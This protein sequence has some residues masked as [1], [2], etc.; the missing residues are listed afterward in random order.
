MWGSI[1]HRASGVALYAGAAVVVA[2][3][4]CLAAGPECYTCFVA[5]MSSP[6]G[7]LLWLG[8]SAAAFYHLFSGLRHLVWDMG[9]GL[10]PKTANSMATWSILLAIAATAAY[11]AWLFLSG[12][13]HL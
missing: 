5:L 12:K 7:L 2:W 10:T 3:L 1:L 4:S 6:I 9:A 13:V 11:W 8:L